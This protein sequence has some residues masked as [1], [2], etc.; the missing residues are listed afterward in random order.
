MRERGKKRYCDAE[1][2]AIN[3]EIIR[4]SVRYKER[5]E[6]KKRRRRRRK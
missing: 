1:M 3:V 2:K 6:G 4:E 5:K